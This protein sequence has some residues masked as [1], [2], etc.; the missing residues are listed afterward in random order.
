M[1]F[2]GLRRGLLSA[3]SNDPNITNLVAEEKD[4][5]ESMAQ[6]KLSIKSYGEYLQL[7]GENNGP[8]LHDITSKLTSCVLEEYSMAF[9]ELED[10]QDRARDQKK[11]IK[12]A[13]EDLFVL[14]GKLKTATDKMTKY[15]R[16]NKN[17]ESVQAEITG[18]ELQIRDETANFENLKRKL[19]Q[20]SFRIQFEGLSKFAQKAMVIAEYGLHMSDQI[21]QTNYSGRDTF[22][23][24]SFVAKDITQ[25][26]MADF[27]AALYNTNQNIK[28]NPR[29]N[30]YLAPQLLNM[31][32]APDYPGPKLPAR[33]KQDTGVGNVN[34]QS[35]LQ[36]S[37]SGQC[38]QASI[39]IAP[40]AEPSAKPSLPNYLEDNPW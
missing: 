19:L 1:S 10:A 4:I 37:S 39:T 6:T 21:P 33:A 7:W 11:L 8:D 30:D 23:T 12:H 27:D 28:L 29:S 38:A 34:L 35:P 2:A 20:E 14:K 32:P 5:V 36:A 16:Q 25:Q 18:L 9:A 26:I 40:S 3:T 15:V 22:P 13:V 24:G 31:P 17:A